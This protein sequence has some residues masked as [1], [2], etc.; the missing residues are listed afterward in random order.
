MKCQLSNDDLKS[1]L[2]LWQSAAKEK[3]LSELRRQLQ[4]RMQQLLNTTD[5]VIWPNL[6]GRAAELQRLIHLLE[7]KIS[8]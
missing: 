2:G 1:C 6:Q 7:G 5:P 4:D 8:S 3:M